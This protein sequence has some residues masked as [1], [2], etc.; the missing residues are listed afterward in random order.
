MFWPVD[1]TH[2][3]TLMLSNLYY[4]FLGFIRSCHFHELFAHWVQKTCEARSIFANGL[5]VVSL[6]IIINHSSKLS[7]LLCRSAKLLPAV[8]L[9]SL[10]GIFS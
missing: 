9:V 5:N 7:I 1:V 10:K 2:V 6:S 3:L 8:E 4:L